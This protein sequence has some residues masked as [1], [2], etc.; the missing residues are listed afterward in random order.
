MNVQEHLPTTGEPILVTGAG[1]FVGGHVARSLAQ[2]G[3]RVRGWTRRVVTPEPGDPA[4]EWFT[5]DLRSSDDRRRAVEG[6]RGVIHVAGWVSLASDPRGMSQIV[7]VDATRALLESACDA[8]ATRFVYTSTLWTTAA[9]IASEPADEDTP[10]NLACIRSP[11]SKSKKEAEALVLSANRPG[12]RTCVLC[13]SLVIGPRAHKPTSMSLLLLM[14]RTH[15]AYLPGGGIPVVDASVLAQ[16]HVRALERAE[17]GCRYVVAGP[18]LSYQ[19]LAR[20]V[21]EVTGKPRWIVTIPDSFERVLSLMAGCIDWLSRG[22]FPECSAPAIR[23]GFLRLHVSG[24]R[25]DALFGLRHPDPLA[26]IRLALADA[27]R[28]GVA[29]WLRIRTTLDDGCG[30]VEYGHPAIASTPSPHPS[31]ADPGE[32]HVTSR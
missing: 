11:Y 2:S 30:S 17:P 14:A 1:G 24:A 16:A 13:P 12:F 31:P 6:M 25:A 7:N 32:S 10:W 15:V 3:Y 26:S 21:A 20:L 28:S 8:G 4:I 29:R 19:S 18:Y 22:R 23:G 27:Q 9:G 5:G